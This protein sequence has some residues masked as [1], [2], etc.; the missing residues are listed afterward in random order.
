MKLGLKVFLITLLTAFIEGFVFLPESYGQFRTGIIADVS[1]QFF[2]AVT[3]PHAFVLKV[4]LLPE[5]SIFQ[6]VHETVNIA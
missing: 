6:P 4:G 5:L 2:S 1:A 3:N